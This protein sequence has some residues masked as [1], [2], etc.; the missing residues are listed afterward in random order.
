MNQSE[1]GAF[2]QNFGFAVY[3]LSVGFSLFWVA[4]SFDRARRGKK[5]YYLLMVAAIAMAVFGT[6][7]SL[8][9]AEQTWISRVWLSMIT[10]SA[11][12][13]GLASTAAYTVADLKADYLR[14]RAIRKANHQDGRPTPPQNALII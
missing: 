9:A 10:R 3:A 11:A 1:L 13:I 5:K 7:L 2:W 8:V 6:S 12:A 4:I 14:D